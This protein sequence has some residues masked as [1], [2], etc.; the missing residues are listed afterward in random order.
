MGYDLCVH[1]VLQILSKW[2]AFHNSIGKYGN[3]TRGSLI[4]STFCLGHGVPTQDPTGT[5][6]KSKF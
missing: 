6:F 5:A 4:P 1:H 2:C 3:K